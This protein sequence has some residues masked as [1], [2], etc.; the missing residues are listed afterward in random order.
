MTR[1][2]VAAASNGG[3]DGFS[4]DDVAWLLR[5]GAVTSPIVGVT[6]PAQ[7]A[8]AIAAVDVALD[9]DEAAYLEEPYVPHPVAVDVEPALERVDEQKGPHIAQMLRERNCRPA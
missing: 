6:K 5:N 3:R 7:L 9:D 2:V 8:E 4:V 1:V